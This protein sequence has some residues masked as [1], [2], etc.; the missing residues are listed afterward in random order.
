M[1]SKQQAARDLVA[2][3]FQVEP[4][5]KAVYVFVDQNGASDAPIRLLE[6]NAATVPSGSVE[7]FSFAPTGQIPYPVQIAEVT[8]E[9]FEALQR[10]PTALPAGWALDQATR[11]DRDRA[12]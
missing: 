10:D 5:L 6:V 11:I 2:H 8:E 1:A 3:H 9:E 12:A 7:V 4:D